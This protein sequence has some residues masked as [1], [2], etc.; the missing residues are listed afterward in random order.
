MHVE[1]NV[2]PHLLLSGRETF[3]SLSR[4]NPSKFDRE[5]FTQYQL[6]LFMTD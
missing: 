1:A 4:Q 5:G 6:V 2:S 3:A